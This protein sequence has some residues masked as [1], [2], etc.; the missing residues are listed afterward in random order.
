MS[1]RDWPPDLQI[2]FRE[3]LDYLCHRLLTVALPEY[4]ALEAVPDP[5]AAQIAQRM[6]DA[7]RKRIENGE[8]L[9][10]EWIEQ[11]HPQEI[12][13]AIRNYIKES[14]CLNGIGTA[15]DPSAPHASDHSLER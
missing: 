11:A 8:W 6:R 9:A 10:S 5:C 2:A 4:H 3:I 1:L 13:N 15:N 14:G 7:I 12:R